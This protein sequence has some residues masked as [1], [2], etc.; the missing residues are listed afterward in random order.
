M[1]SI[2]TPGFQYRTYDIKAILDN[3]DNEQMIDII[4]E[5]L[6][7]YGYPLGGQHGNTTVDHIQDFA[8]GFI[9][10]LIHSGTVKIE[11]HLANNYNSL[12]DMF[13]LLATDDDDADGENLA[14]SDEDNVDDDGS[15]DD[16]IV[17]DEDDNDEVVYSDSNGD[18]PPSPF[19]NFRNIGDDG[20]ESVDEPEDVDDIDLASASLPEPS[21]EEEKEERYIFRAPQ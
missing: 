16:E 12:I 9:E 10:S 8:Q 11:S 20:I 18:T 7:K 4:A 19:D 17:E 2:E 21:S 5:R 1:N 6:D 13:D 3:A 15:C 14:D